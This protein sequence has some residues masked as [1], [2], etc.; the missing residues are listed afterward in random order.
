[1]YVKSLPA[2]ANRTQV[3]RYLKGRVLNIGRMVR[4]YMYTEWAKQ[5]QTVKVWE[6]RQVDQIYQGQQSQKFT[7]RWAM[8]ILIVLCLSAAITRRFGKPFCCLFVCVFGCLCVCYYY[9]FSTLTM[10][11]YGSQD[12]CSPLTRKLIV[13]KSKQPLLGKHTHSINWP[14]PYYYCYI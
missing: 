5:A 12:S 6:T 14:P 10:S 8:L 7:I 9:M 4:Y 1:M 13:N 3:C 2:Q 11:F